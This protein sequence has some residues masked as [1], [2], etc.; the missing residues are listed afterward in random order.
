MRGYHIWRTNL[1]KSLK[2][3][4]TVIDYVPVNT[5]DFTTDI[6]DKE[7]NCNDILSYKIA[8]TGK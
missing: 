3:A 6:I 5:L 4:F 7:C 8:T 2:K 1:Y